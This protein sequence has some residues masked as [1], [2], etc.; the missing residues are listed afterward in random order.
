MTDH[1]GYAFGLQPGQDVLSNAEDLAQQFR[2][3]IADRVERE[4][5]AEFNTKAEAAAKKAA[6]EGR[7]DKVGAEKA[8]AAL[9]KLIAEAQTTSVR[10]VRITR[11]RQ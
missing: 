4:V 6:D 5:T 10:I 7:E 1:H 2:N 9:T 8:Q 3:R 11:V